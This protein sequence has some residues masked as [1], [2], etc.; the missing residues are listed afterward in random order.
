VL[1]A[2]E[3]VAFKL[4]SVLWVNNHSCEPATV[5]VV[6]LCTDKHPDVSCEMK[7]EIVADV[8]LD[9]V[10]SASRVK[11]IKERCLAVPRRFVCILGSCTC[12]CC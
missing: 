1:E 8:V 12:A 11:L 7:Q 5:F 2:A 3:D 9:D 6:M 10:I 4:D